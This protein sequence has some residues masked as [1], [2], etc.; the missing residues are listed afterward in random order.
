MSV[1]LFSATRKFFA[2][3]AAIFLMSICS[4]KAYAVVINFDDLTYVPE[5]PEFPSFGDYPLGNEY[6]SQGLLISNAFLLPYSEDDDLISWGNFLLAGGSGSP[7]ILSFVGQLPTFVGMYIGGNPLGV[8]HTS[9]YGPAGF[10]TSHQK[11]SS[12][13]EYVTFE[14]ATGIS[15]IEMGATQQTRVSGGKIDDITYTYASV[16][17]SSSIG[18]L[19]LAAMA[20]FG[21]RMKLQ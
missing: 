15:Y 3:F 21:R 10:F 2:H 5:N 14:S 17:E 1:L 12:G 9:A 6:R 19:M 16:P 4:I 11:D 8:L 18:L 13:W 20:L 7:M